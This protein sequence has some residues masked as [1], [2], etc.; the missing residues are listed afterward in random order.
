MKNWS[1]VC[2][3]DK[4]AD[5]LEWSKWIQIENSIIGFQRKFLMPLSATDDVSLLKIQSNSLQLE[6]NTLDRNWILWTSHT[7]F[8]LIVRYDVVEK[9]PFNG[10]AN[11]VFLLKAV[12]FLLT[13]ES[14]LAL[15]NRRFLFSKEHSAASAGVQ[16]FRRPH[17][18]DMSNCNRKHF[19]YNVVYI[20][21]LVVDLVVD[22]SQQAI[23]RSA[24]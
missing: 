4:V 13:R 24:K 22:F 8:I 9:I 20:E 21:S 1:K 3:T 11:L 2:T 14:R 16:T 5:S 12:K 7:M 19:D 6:I 10:F 15:Q 23:L 18:F 17:Q